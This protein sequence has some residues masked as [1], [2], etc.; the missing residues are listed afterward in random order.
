[1]KSYVSEALGRIEEILKELE[2]EAYKQGLDD[3]ETEMYELIEEARDKSYNAGYN[4][5][6]SD[7][8]KCNGGDNES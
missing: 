4:A 7:G 6:Y 8:V 1:M 5:G 3:Q 2:W